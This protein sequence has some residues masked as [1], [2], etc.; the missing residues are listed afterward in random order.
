MDNELGF[1]ASGELRV[2]IGLERPGTYYVRIRR[3]GGTGGDD[4]G[5]GSHG[6]LWRTDKRTACDSDADE[7][8]ATATSATAVA[9]GTRTPMTSAVV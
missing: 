9:M 3:G 5:P 7:P 8:P 1:S 2:A 4:H 6:V